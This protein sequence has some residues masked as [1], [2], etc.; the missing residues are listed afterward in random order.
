MKRWYAVY[1]RARGEAW[2]AGNLIRQ[3]FEVYFPKIRKEVRHARRIR[4]VLAPMFPRY[5]LVR[6]DTE[7]QRWRSVNG[8][9][10]VSHIIC[11]GEIPASVPDEVISAIRGREDQSGVVRLMPNGLKPGDQVRVREG[12]FADYSALLEEMC[13]QERAILLL[14]LMGRSVRVSV[15]LDNIAAAG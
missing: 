8:T 14:E 10:G 13:G 2:A 3:G 11:Q 9:F 12:A 5:L 7:R 6:M 4:S 1:T 15:P